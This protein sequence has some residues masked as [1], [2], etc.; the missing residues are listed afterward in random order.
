LSKDIWSLTFEPFCQLEPVITMLHL[1][2]EQKGENAHVYVCMCVCVCVCVPFCFKFFFKRIRSVHHS[3]RR[4]G[5][6]W[7]HVN[8]AKNM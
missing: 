7:Y 5:T 6:F 2:V 3:K 8:N 1:P 4:R